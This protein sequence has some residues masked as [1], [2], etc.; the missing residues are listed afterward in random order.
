MDYLATQDDESVR[1]QAQLLHIELPSSSV[2]AGPPI[3]TVMYVS[4][5]PALIDYR[6]VSL[7]NNHGLR[8]LIN[9]DSRNNEGPSTAVT[10]DSIAFD[11]ARIFNRD[12]SWTLSSFC[13]PHGNRSL[14]KS[15]AA[16][17]CDN[18]NDFADI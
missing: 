1:A 2:S 5:C 9:G 10:L 18:A 13:L 8:S 3:C 17:H 15:P 16:S 11:I 12:I 14:Y 6:T 4:L 7:P